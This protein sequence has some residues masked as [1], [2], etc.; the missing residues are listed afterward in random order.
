MTDAT[1]LNSPCCQGNP[2]SNRS[3][4]RNVDNNNLFIAHLPMIF[5][6]E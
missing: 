5:R 2:V 3:H 4:M 1:I 6:F